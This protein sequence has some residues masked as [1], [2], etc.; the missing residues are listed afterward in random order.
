MERKNCYFISFI[1]L[2]VVWLAGCDSY[3]EPSELP[4]VPSAAEQD[5]TLEEDVTVIRTLKIG[6][7]M[8][9][10]VEERWEKDRDM[11][12]EA[13]EALGAE[14]EVKAAN[15]NDALQ[16]AQAETLI[17]QGVDLLVLVPHNAEAAATI[18][19]KAQMAGIPVISYDRLVK[20]ANI[21]L[22]ISFDNEKVG[23]LQAEAITALVP[24]GK[25]VYIGGASTDNNAHL[26]KEGVYNVLQP[27][28]ERGD[29]TVVY[30]QWTEAWM[31]ANAKQ[32]MQAALIANDNDI[33]AVIAANDATAG[34]VIEALAE[35]GLAGKVPVAGQDAELAGLQHIVNG[36]QAMTVY[37]SIKSLTEQA[38]EIAVRM[39]SGEVIETDTTINNGKKDVPTVFLTPVAVDKTNIEETII[40]DGFH[41]AEDIYHGLPNK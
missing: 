33:D 8:D 7:S 41:R 6:L 28:I 39:A 34:G 2:I 27:F 25:Y 38:A 26:L 9:T 20:N 21:D 23:E 35:Q 11:F 22:Y 3:A 13:V 31:P 32:N 17:S 14:V 24:E 1:L 18:V 30:D 12:K 15:G 19:G 4:S 40:A 29:I 36:E 10:L 16:I 5:H 37:K